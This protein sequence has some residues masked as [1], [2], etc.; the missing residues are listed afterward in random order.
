MGRKTPV[1]FVTGEKS[2]HLQH[3]FLPF[4]MKYQRLASEHLSPIPSPDFGLGTLDFGPNEILRQHLG[5]RRSFAAFPRPQTAGTILQPVL[6][7]ACRA[8]SSRRGFGAEAEASERRRKKKIYPFPG[9]PRRT[10]AYRSGPPRPISPQF[11][12]L[13]LKWGTPTYCG[14]S[15][16]IPQR[17]REKNPQGPLRGNTRPYAA[18]RG[19][20]IGGRSRIAA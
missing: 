13:N 9:V 4:S 15:P 2:N 7:A 18:I 1:F 5:L 11:C 3:D 6:R 20:W 14:A 16:T 8:D 19:K 17:P 10:Y 12:I